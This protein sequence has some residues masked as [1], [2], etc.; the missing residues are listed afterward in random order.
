MSRTRP[1]TR[2]SA[3]LA[4]D[5]DYY[6][7]VRATDY[8]APTAPWSE[9]RHFRMRWNFEARLLTPLNNAIRTSYPFFTWAPIPGAERY[10]IQI[11]E[12]TSFASPIADEKIYNV[13]ALRAAQVGQRHRRTRD[14]FWRVRGAG[15]A[16]QP[17]AVERSRSFRPHTCQHPPEPD[18]PALLLPAR[19]GQHAGAQR[20]DHRLAAVRLGH[21]ASVLRPGDGPSSAAA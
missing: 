5:Q 10:Q 19:H 11:D 12:S 2:R 3:T 21:G 20:P 15:C 7:R 14:Y 18:L 13:T 9:V 6:W 1:T 17:H 8:A 16:G 4:N